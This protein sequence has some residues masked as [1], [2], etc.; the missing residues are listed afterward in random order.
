MIITIN[1]S[2]FSK[3]YEWSFDFFVAVAESNYA[4]MIRPYVTL[5][6]KWLFTVLVS[7]LVGPDR[8]TPLGLKNS[9]RPR[10]QNI[11][12]VSSA[13]VC[14]LEKIFLHHPVNN[15]Y[16][17]ENSTI[18]MALELQIVFLWRGLQFKGLAPRHSCE[19]QNKWRSR[20]QE[21]VI[22]CKNVIITKC[23]FIFL[24]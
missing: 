8:K 9:R 18:K 13:R 21:A 14:N 10:S 16:V 6:K 11:F 17:L 22:T 12:R 4:I 24:C 15:V 2:D 5:V 20:P 3:L 19:D 7:V 23:S 1:W